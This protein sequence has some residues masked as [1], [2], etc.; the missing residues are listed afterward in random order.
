MAYEDDC[1]E[2]SYMPFFIKIFTRYPNKTAC[3]N[4]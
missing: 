3:K 4:E 2:S 1:L